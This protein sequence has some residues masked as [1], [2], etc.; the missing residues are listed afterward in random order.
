MT[1]FAPERTLGDYLNAV[2]RRYALL[3]AVGAVIAVTAAGFAMFLPAIY[4]SRAVILI[5]QQEIPVDLVRS[6][7]T[8]FA[9]QRIQVISQRVMTTQNLVEII[10]KYELYVEEREREPLE[11]VLAQM[12]DDIGRDMISAE[13]VDP[14]SGRPTEA[15][16]AFSLSFQSRNPTVAQRVAT[17]LVSLYLNE[18]IKTRTAAAAD[19]ALFLK[20]EAEGLR[21]K[22]SELEASLAEF[23]RE[24]EGNL[25][26]L[27]QF[28]REMVNRTELEISEVR[29]T[30]DSLRQNRILLEADL[31]QL[32]PFDSG[33]EG[34]DSAVE[35]M[36]AVESR[37]TAAQAAYGPEH[38]DVKRLSKQ[39]QALRAEADPVAA[40]AIYEDELEVSKSAFA[41]LLEQYGGEHPDVQNAEKRIANVEKKIAALPNEDMAREPT[42]PAYIS[43]VTRIELVGTEI[44]SQGRKLAELEAR[45]A[46]D[47]DSL[48]RIPD[49]EAEY[50]EITREYVTTTAKYQEVTAKQMEASLSENLETERKGEKFTLIEPP[51]VPERPAKPN[52]PAIFFVG[53]FL[54]LTGGFGSVA[55]AEAMDNKVRGRTGV[56]HMLTA[57]PLAVIPYV[58]GDEQRAPPHRK[59]L[60]LA[61]IVM[62]LIVI[63]LA[64]FH[65]FYKPL[66]VAW[67]IIMRK[68]GF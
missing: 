30:I 53:L 65:F 62:G 45:L 37:L 22:V 68:Y 44:A 59:W 8:S 10:E 19:T 48:R 11:L 67:F 15:T 18:N 13:V 46:K 57:P 51:L 9:D 14:R 17:E 20:S 49:V 50:R 3:L 41:Q 23:K 43:V 6:T 33:E 2:K 61:A 31:D 38:P 5:E 29:R 4:Q 55:V 63:A 27:E 12:R 58:Y 64:L 60:I 1:E 36:R 39:A 28:T 24:N 16:I 32:D 25:P 26:E 66:D 7:V 54:A 56:Q 34:E 35:R 42:N 52:R 40:R 47:L 21:L